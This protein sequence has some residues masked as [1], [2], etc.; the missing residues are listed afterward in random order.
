MS[1]ATPVIKIENLSKRFGATQALRNVSME[2]NSSEVLALLGANGAGKSTIIKILAGIYSADSGSLTSAS[3]G[4]I[5]EVNF[6]FIHQDLGLVEWM[7]VGESIA[8]GSEY[9]RAG[10]L[11]NW[12]GVRKMATEALANVAPHINVNDTISNLT[13]ADRSLVAIAR[14]LY[15]KSDVLIL[16]EPTSALDPLVQ[17][18]FSELMEEAKQRGT[19]VLLSSHVLSEVEHLADRVVIINAGRLLRVSDMESL[20]HRTVQA[21]VLTFVSPIPTQVFLPVPGVRDAQS[22]GTHV[23]LNVVGPVTEVLRTAVAHGVIRIQTS[24]PSLDD[25]FYSI[26]NGDV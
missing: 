15:A 8:L 25:I 9:P 26:V 18:E 21:M 1:P 4:S 6:A 22:R 3:G 23:T 16:D 13:R 5:N 24:E 14:A 17:H 11:I 20:Q 2:I 19:A 10:K 12:S 7:T